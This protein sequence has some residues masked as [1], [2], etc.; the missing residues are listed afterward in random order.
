M[1]HLNG[2]TGDDAR[3]AGRR[4]AEQ[5]MLCVIC[6]GWINKGEPFAHYYHGFPMHADACISSEKSTR[7]ESETLPKRAA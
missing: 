1:E 7:R 2:Q 6:G 4:I 3:T 5:D